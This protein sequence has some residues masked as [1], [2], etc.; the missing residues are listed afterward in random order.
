MK[1][2]VRHH[3]V[4][5]SIFFVFSSCS[6]RNTWPLHSLNRSG[7]LVESTSRKVRPVRGYFLRNCENFVWTKITGGFR[8]ILPVSAPVKRYQWKVCSMESLSVSK[9]LISECQCVEDT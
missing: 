3:D 7:V 2:E 5:I 1:S 4:S 9:L 8:E 6:D